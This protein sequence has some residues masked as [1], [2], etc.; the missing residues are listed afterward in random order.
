M[1]EERCEGVTGSG[2][3]VA[4]VGLEVRDGEWGL[5]G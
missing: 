5:D 2:I 1:A 3:K 4:Q